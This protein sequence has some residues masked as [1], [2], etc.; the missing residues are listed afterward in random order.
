MSDKVK[1]WMQLIVVVLT[2]I[3][4]TLGTTK[5]AKA[6]GLG[7]RVSVFSIGR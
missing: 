4:T 1:W 7:E 3:M 6:C 5:S 2:S